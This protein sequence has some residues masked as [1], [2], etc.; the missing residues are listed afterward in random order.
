M[1]RR[2]GVTID[3]DTVL[4]IGFFM[5]M[6]LM[7]LVI[8]FNWVGEKPFILFHHIPEVAVFYYLGKFLSQSLSKNV[9]APL[10][11]IAATNAVAVAITRSLLAL[12]LSAAF[13]LAMVS[14]WLMVRG[15]SRPLE[16]RLDTPV[17]DEG[18][19][20]DRCDDYHGNSG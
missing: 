18:D 20:Q 7:L 6:M 11:V 17:A 4:A 16:G 1:M 12:P 3:A 8:D 14:G 10:L 2:G 19:D 5:F 9:C 15:N 13:S